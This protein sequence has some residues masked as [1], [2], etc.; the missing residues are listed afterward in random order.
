MGDGTRNG[1]LA[2]GTRVRPLDLGLIRSDPE[3][4]R[5]CRG[6]GPDRRRIKPASVRTNPKLVTFAP[7]VRADPAVRSQSNPIL[8]SPCRPGPARI[9]VHFL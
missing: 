1:A 4:G 6:I 2:R 3:P 5:D 9:E 8:S 7:L